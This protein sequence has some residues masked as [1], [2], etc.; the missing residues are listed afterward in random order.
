MAASIRCYFDTINLEQSGFC[1]TFSFKILVSERK[2]KNNLINCESQKQN[3][4]QFSYILYNIYV[5]FYYKI[6]WF[7]QDLKVKICA[8]KSV[9][10]SHRENSGPATRGHVKSSQMKNETPLQL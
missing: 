6:F 1:T 3:L 4:L 9:L 2:Y 8:F 10:S 7:C 5:M